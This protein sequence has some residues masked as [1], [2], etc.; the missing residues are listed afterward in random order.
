MFTK[1]LDWLTAQ[2][3]PVN[4]FA[5]NSTGGIDPRMTV[6]TANVLC[7]NVLSINVCVYVLC[8]YHS[9]TGNE[10]LCVDSKHDFLCD[11]QTDRE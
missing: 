9:V 4:L 6:K 7:V 8:V 3:Q 11:R 10:A 5:Y 1:T 2:H